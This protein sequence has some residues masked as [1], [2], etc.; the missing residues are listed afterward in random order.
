MVLS[1]LPSA[2][3]LL[4][5]ALQSL[6]ARAQSQNL[7]LSLE[8]MEEV[9]RLRM[10]ESVF[11][12]NDVSPMIVV[13]VAPYFEESKASYANFA[14][15][16]LQRVFPT[17]GI[18]VCTPCMTPQTTQDSRRLEM[19]IG[20]PTLE[21]IRE[22]D[23]RYRKD[24]PEAKAA[25]WLDET[26]EGVTLRI[27]DLQTARVVY[28]DN[29]NPNLVWT[30]RSSRNFDRA[31]DIHSRLRGQ[32]LSHKIYDFGIYPGPSFALD[33]VEQWGSGNEHLSGISFSLYN[34]TLGIGAS[35]GRA[36]SE[37]ANTMIG[38]KVH[39]G[40]VEAIGRSLTK[41]DTNLLGPLITY[42]GFVRVP[43]PSFGNY[44]VYAF[45]NSQSSFGLGIT[46]TFP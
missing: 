40:V 15:A 29:V 46:A 20:A 27:V 33:L 28:A 34:P 2:I 23:S 37:F 21:E 38:G 14:V 44:G 43:V 31:R 39:V 17:S 16:S 42:T 19:R 3:V 10:E 22:I 12:V 13:S 6:S 26:K 45:V 35:Y 5:L 11:T 32:S 7:K 41:S 36:F 4:F 30:Q 1:R 18:R 8:R 25:V 24:A 9:L